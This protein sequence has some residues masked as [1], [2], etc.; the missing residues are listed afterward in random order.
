[1]PGRLR[2]SFRYGNLTEHLGLLLLKGIAAVAEVSRP[3]D[4][5]LDAVASLLR[6]DEDG[7]CYAEDTFVVQLKSDSATTLKYRNHELKWLLGQSQPMFIGLVGFA[8]SRISLY[9]TLYVNQA[10]L[11]LQVE[12]ATI[13]FG[14][15]GVRSLF[16]GQETSPWAGGPENSATVW[17]G[18]PLISWT[19]R[20]LSDVEWA[21]RA[22]EVLK[23]F[24][25]IARREYDLLSFNQCSQLV[26]STNDP[27]SIKS[28]SM[29]IKGHPDD[30]PLLA[31][32]CAPCLHALMLQA[33]S[34]PDQSGNS[35]MIP[36]ISLAAA[37]RDHG[38]DVDPENVFAKFFVALH[39]RP[40]DSNE[41]DAK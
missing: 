16:A 37:L 7:N 34:M 39:G 4:V 26:W 13:R 33:L 28:T 15:S 20:D 36:L 2:S 30:L 19:I 24:L 3:E 38:A 31:E 35:L 10:I 25:G 12:Q 41:Q 23:R 11:A 22:Y 14:T 29:M 21:T 6:R 17:L 32:H 40:S 27:D 1:M 18:D 8:E 5:G 9:P